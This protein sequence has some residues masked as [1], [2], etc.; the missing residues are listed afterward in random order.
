MAET[1]GMSLKTI[2]TNYLV[3]PLKSNKSNDLS[4]FVNSV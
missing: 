3:I 2:G 4:S 1:G